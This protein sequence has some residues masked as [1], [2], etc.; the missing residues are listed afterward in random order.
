MVPPVSPRGR[1]DSQVGSGGPRARAQRRLA[2]GAE[3]VRPGGQQDLR[4]ASGGRVRVEAVQ[5]Q[6]DN[7]SPWGDAHE[8]M[9]AKGRRLVGPQDRPATPLQWFSN[10]RQPSHRPWGPYKAGAGPPRSESGSSQT[11]AISLR[12]LPR[13]VTDQ[14]WRR[15]C[16]RGRMQ[17]RVQAHK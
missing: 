1:G 2:R 6:G 13:W 10:C 14:A 4:W 5:R 3:A 17:A 9:T 16:L 8:A 12:V 11:A 7:V 15:C